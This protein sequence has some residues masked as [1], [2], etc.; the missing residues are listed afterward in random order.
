MSKR[1]QVIAFAENMAVLVNSGADLNAALAMIIE[2]HPPGSLKS[3][4]K[5]IR[6]ELQRG[7]SLHK[8]LSAFP[9]I[10]DQY[11]IGMVKS[12][13][14][15]GQLADSL[16]RLAQQLENNRELRAQISTALIY[17][18]ILIVAMGLSL[19]IVLGLI[20]PE[21]T[22]LFA[23]FG[24]ELS[25]AGHILLAF[26][27]FVDAWGL[28]IFGCIAV[29]I[30]LGW[31]F[32]ETI[33]P[34]RRVLITLKY[35]PVIRKI[36]DQIDFARFTATLASLLE[37][38]LPQTEALAIA[39]DSF[40]QS[41]NREQLGEVIQRVNQGEPLGACLA[42]I[43]GIDR[44]YAQSISNGERGG[45]LPQTLRILATRLEKDFS[46]TAQRTALLVEPILIISLGLVIGAVVYAIFSA[47]QN[48]GNMPL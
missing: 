21:F 11:Y 30:L 10:F 15:S 42:D 36:F 43:T 9:D 46:R 13:E 27:R 44:L 45:Q 20:L 33:K 1:A 26:G 32:R 23:S 19:V 28:W 31:L 18:A 41:R 4:L 34:G 22:E 12:G 35:V 16:A 39:A 38:G 48:L 2:T 5:E 6:A 40:T 25:A 17:P 37:S 47:L 7:Q 14:V 29:G 24:N 8:A 3:T